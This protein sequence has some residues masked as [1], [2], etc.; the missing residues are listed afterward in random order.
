[1][2]AKELIELKKYELAKAADTK[3]EGVEAGLKA[4][5]GVAAVM[6][7]ET[8]TSAA[9]GLYKVLFDADAALVD[10]KKASDDVD[11]YAVSANTEY[12]KAVAR[13]VLL[14]AALEPL[15]V[16]AANEK[17]AY[18]KGNA[19]TVQAGID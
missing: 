16:V 14:V 6:N 17:A 19:A 13:K 11:K 8:V 15:K 18:D 10:P 3:Q 1:M 5:V 7:G 4:E 2:I 12:E 9:T